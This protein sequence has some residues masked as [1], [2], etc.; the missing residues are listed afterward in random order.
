MNMGIVHRPFK[1]APRLGYR[2][3]RKD[4]GN[5]VEWGCENIKM[6]EKCIIEEGLTYRETAERFQVSFTCIYNAARKFDIRSK[7]THQKREKRELKFS[8]RMLVIDL[9]TIG[10]SISQCAEYIGCAQSTLQGMVDR[11]GKIRAIATEK[12]KKMINETLEKYGYG[13][14]N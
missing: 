2:L 7:H 11:N 1:Q 9:L 13:Q 10:V 4:G 5:N 3:K 8:E 6:L 12:R 14:T